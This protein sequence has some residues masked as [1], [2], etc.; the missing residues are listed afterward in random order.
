[1]E[2]QVLGGKTY[3]TKNKSGGHTFLFLHNLDVIA[4]WISNIPKFSIISLLKNN[5]NKQ[6]Y[7]SKVIESNLANFNSV[8][9]FQKFFNNSS[10]SSSS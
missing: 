6:I 4:L 1:V 9:D 10:S 5:N 8:H 7:I 2:R 3:Y